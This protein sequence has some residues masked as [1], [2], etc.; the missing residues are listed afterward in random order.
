MTIP[1]HLF[2]LHC[3]TNVACFFV[4]KKIVRQQYYSRFCTIEKG[5]KKLFEP[6]FL[7]SMAEFYF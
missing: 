3:F 7:A 1:Q 6:T 5:G 2:L 4:Q